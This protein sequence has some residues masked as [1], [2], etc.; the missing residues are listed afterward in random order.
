[1]IGHKAKSDLGVTFSSKSIK[2]FQSALTKN[3]NIPDDDPHKSMLQRVLDAFARGDSTLIGY[4]VEN[5][6]ICGIYDFSEG[7]KKERVGVFAL[8]EELTNGWTCEKARELVGSL[9]RKYLEQCSTQRLGSGMKSIRTDV[10]ATTSF[11]KKITRINIGSGSSLQTTGGG[12]VID[13]RLMTNDYDFGASVAKYLT[14]EVKVEFPNPRISAAN[15]I[16]FRDTISSDGF[17]SDSSIEITVNEWVD[18]GQEVLPMRVAYSDAGVLAAITSTP[19]GGIETTYNVAIGR[20]LGSAL[21]A[22][23]PNSVLVIDANN[24]GLIEAQLYPVGGASYAVSSTDEAKG[25]TIKY[26]DYIFV[27]MADDPSLS[28]S[29][30]DAKTGSSM[31]Q[32]FKLENR[33]LSNTLIGDALKVG[34]LP[35]WV[36]EY[37]GNDLE[38]K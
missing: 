19:P 28:A 27:G 2:S 33:D 6:T 3:A 36:I 31:A 32:F 16:E 37:L 23:A 24:D 8:S 34:E 11:P 9:F 14:S 25:A 21:D 22:Q 20:Q 29:F 35:T 10:V 7:V 12:I 5:E 4:P 13:T 26:R 30:S 1:M 15:N 18:A 17:K 38:L